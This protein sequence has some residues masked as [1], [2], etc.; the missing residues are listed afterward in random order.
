MSNLQMNFD[1]EEDP[2]Q[3]IPEL[4]RH[5]Y[6]LGWASGT[7]GGLS[8]REANRIY[9]APS[10]VQK[11]RIKPSEMFVLDEDGKILEAP[12]NKALRCSECLGLF[13]I[14]FKLRD[15]GCCIHS[16]SINANLVSS[17]YRAENIHKLRQINGLKNGALKLAA[18]EFR[19]SRQEMI[20]GIKF[21]SSGKTMEYTDTLIVPIIDNVLHERDLV[22]SMRQ[23]VERY[24]DTNAVLVRDHG[25]Y[26]W[27]RDWR[28]AKSQAE[29]YEYLF[30]LK[31][32][33]VRLGFDWILG[34]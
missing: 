16:H 30:R 23:V 2:R 17:L 15:A 4:C 33:A 13:M 7:G 6:N 22:E 29:C 31:L 27:G 3:L 20:K 10:G 14:A 8:I 9:C 25:V 18:D 32:E 12:E 24:P 21:C 34:D 19:I 26:V 1:H 11:E 5:F 28:Q